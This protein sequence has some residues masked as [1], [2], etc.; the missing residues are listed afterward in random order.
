MNP[1]LEHEAAGAEAGRQL[2]QSHW[3]TYE[4][5][6]A[7]GRPC[8]LEPLAED[9][10]PSPIGLA[11]WDA[12][13]SPLRVQRPAV[14]R[15]WLRQGSGAAGALR[16]REPFVEV[17]W[18]EALDLVAAELRRVRERHGNEAIFGGSYGWS[19]AGRFHHAQSQVHRFLNSLGGY[20]RSVDTYSLGAARVLLPHVL[21]PMEELMASHHGWDV[22][23]EHTKLLLA[24]G[25]LPAKNAQISAGGTAEHRLR[26]GLAKLAAAGCR[27]VNVSP[28]RDDFDA[29][30]GSVEWL[31]IRPGTDAAAMLAL[32]GELVRSGRHDSAFL[33]SH[34]VGFE[35]WADYLLGREDG[36]VKDAAWAAP[37]T[38]LDPQRLR[39]LADEL[40]GTRSFV[41]LSW[42]L[43]RA[44]HG[45][46]P[47]WA[48]LGLAAVLGQIGLPGGGLGVGYG[49]V[50]L[51]GSPHPR[52]AGPTLPQGRNPVGAF[53]PVARIADMLLHPGAPFDYNGR[54]CTYPE[55]ELVYWAG[56]N[57]FHHHQDL[58]RLARAWA[59]PATVIAH[60]Q[61][62]NA[63]ARR[64]DIVLPAT[65][66]LERD[67]IGWSVREPL[68]VAMKALQP[69]PGQARDDYA[70]FSALARRLGVEA[71][72]T[73]GR[74]VH[75][76]LRA[77]YDQGAANARA[78]GIELPGFDAFWQAGEAR[79]EGPAA[80]VVMLGE[81]RAD[82]QAHPLKTPSGRIELHSETIAGFDYEDCP[83][84]PVWLEPVEWLG[85][86]AAAR[87]PLHLISDQPHTKLHSQLDHSAYSLANKVAGRE[88]LR[89]HP[90]DARRRGIADGDLVRVFNDRGACLAG[91]RLDAATLPG[92]LRLAT[93]A[94]WDP[95]FDAP[96]ALDRH[97]NPNVL[98]RDVGAS[99]LSQGCSA[100]SC[101]VEV[102]RYDGPATPTRVFDGPSLEAAGERARR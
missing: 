41:N 74:T 38:G 100:Q 86:A 19:S 87:H 34:C 18:D 4:V 89:M 42:S 40:V 5:R 62:W 101:L 25:G 21:A 55:I 33:K 49:P 83:G 51:M 99:K 64:A 13:R 66:T 97:G 94:W 91:A 46:Q 80:P 79:I 60:E 70:I 68:M 43:Q 53:I 50:N 30:P 39:R 47:Y 28:V 26:A 10:D 22:L 15:S 81:F 93:G 95:D 75:E 69:P 71:A 102:Q 17:E 37:I 92:V 12:Y 96:Q 77:M 11:M 16:G 90:D 88:P 27:L 76:W 73:E 98:T 24:F 14:R 65:S 9:P 57:P 20:V 59:R 45:E 6:R 56:G 29:P 67:D 63:H 36:I 1:D 23:A 84:H 31:P 72:Y 54:R 48:G 35:R 8:G 82:P 32:A 7:E 61:F 44:E 85:G 3:G 58:N 52:F 2:T 78:A